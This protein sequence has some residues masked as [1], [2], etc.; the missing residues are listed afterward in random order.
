M[1]GRRWRVVV[2]GLALVYFL[3]PLLSAAEFS[4]RIP[5]G[6]YGVANYLTIFGDEVLLSSLLVSLQIAVVTAV[7]VLLLA[8]LRF[9]W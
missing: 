8:D 2:L 4:L 1:R 3:V 6:G 5:G 9:P 7:L